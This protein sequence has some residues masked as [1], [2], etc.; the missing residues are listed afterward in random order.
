MSLDSLRAVLANGGEHLGDLCWWSLSDAQTPREQLVAIW[1]AAGLDPAL[2]PDE[3]TCERAL[4]AAVRESQVGHPDHLIR[5]GKEDPGELVYAILKEQRHDDGSV[6]FS[7]EAK[8]RLDR[9]S[10]QV[11]LDVTHEIGV[12]VL[13]SYR[14]LRSVHTADE[15]RRT[16]VRALQAF[17]AVTLRDHGGIYWVPRSF[18]PQMRQLQSAVE[19]IGTSRFYLLPVHRNAES[20]RTL[21]EVARGSLEQELSSLQAEMTAFLESPPERPST[22]ARRFE[23]YEALRGRAYLYRDVLSMELKDLD[24]HLDRLTA[25]LEGLLEAKSAA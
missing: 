7:T 12:T 5:L 22:L 3:P 16:V 13:A 8:V 1:G 11:D 20:S 4:K 10:E 21:T 9:S 15:V 2:L 25:E 24:E 19:Q 17:A 14:R 18:A 23:A 6:D